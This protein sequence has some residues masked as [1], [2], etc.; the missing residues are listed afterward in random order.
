[1]ERLVPTERHVLSPIE[2]EMV[3]LFRMFTGSQKKL[4]VDMMSQLPFDKSAEAED[5]AAKM[6][7]MIGSCIKE[8][9]NEG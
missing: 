3:G 9:S 6:S 8:H 4:F 5:V 7:E 1:M 2:C